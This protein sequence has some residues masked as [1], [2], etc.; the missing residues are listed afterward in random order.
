[1]GVL[2]D[3]PASRS[4]INDQQNSEANIMAVAQSKKDAV[5]FSTVGADE[6]LEW[7]A[8]YD[9]LY[10]FNI[11]FITAVLLIV[12]VSY[13]LIRTP[14]KLYIKFLTIPLLFFLLYSTMDK[15]NDVLGYAYPTIPV[16]KVI[17]MDGTR[18]GK[19]IELWVKHL[20]ETDTRLYKMPYSK[21]LQKKLKEGKKARQQGNP[22]VLEWK[23]SKSKQN[24][25]SGQRNPGKFIVYS[26]RDLME[27]AKKNYEQK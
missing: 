6:E 17:V 26:L 24:G 27:G 25:R 14:A 7:N 9:I 23:E 10:A 2:V 19:V 22:M 13:I 20:G 12:L 8:W 15:L 4:I 3:S 16:G 11:E 1:M 21:E 18:Q 5:D